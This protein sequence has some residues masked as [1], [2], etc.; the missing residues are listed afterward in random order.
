[1]PLC[2]LSLLT[3]KSD[4]SY[5][6]SLAFVKALLAAGKRPIIAGHFKRQMI[7][8]ETIDA[9]RIKAD[10]LVLLPGSTEWPE[11]LRSQIKSE[12]RLVVGIPSKLLDAF[13]EHNRKLMSAKPVELTGSLN[14]PR[15]AQSTQ[16]LEA[17]DSLIQWARCVARP[18]QS[19]THIDTLQVR[20]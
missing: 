20:Q 14:N 7:K 3:L 1:M 18:G 10:L 4:D 6:A 5:A 9:D 11:S 8:A 12:Y 17:T 15:L 2:T 13:P 16:K 19:F